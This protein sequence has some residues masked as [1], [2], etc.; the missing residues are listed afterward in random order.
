MSDRDICSKMDRVG[1]P[2]NIQY[3]CYN[4]L[5]QTPQYF[6]NQQC[7]SWPGNPSFQTNSFPYRVP[8]DFKVSGS[9]AAYIPAVT[10]NDVRSQLDTNCKELNRN[11]PGCSTTD[12]CEWAYQTMGFTD[13]AGNYHD[14]GVARSAYKAGFCMYG[15]RCCFMDASFCYRTAFDETYKNSCINKSLETDFGLSSTVWL[16]DTFWKLPDVPLT[17]LADGTFSGAS[18]TS[19]SYNIYQIYC[20]PSWCASNPAAD[21]V[22]FANCKNS[23]TMIGG[24]QRHAALAASGECHDWYTNSTADFRFGTH[25]WQL[26]DTMIENYCQNTPY[27]VDS[28][29]CNCVGGQPDR[30]QVPNSTYYT[31]CSAVGIGPGDC[32]GIVAPVRAAVQSQSSPPLLLSNPI[33]ANITCKQAISEFTSFATRNIHQQRVSCPEQSCFLTVLG[34]TFTAGNVNSSSVYIGSTDQ[35]CDN[36]SISATAP[37]YTVQ[38]FPTVWFWSNLKQEVLNPAQTALINLTNV[39][40]AGSGEMMQYSVTHGP[41]PSWL[42]YEGAPL[43]G[44]LEVGNVAGFSLRQRAQFAPQS[45]LIPFTFTALNGDSTFSQQ[46]VQLQVGVVATD[47]AVPV[48]PNPGSDTNPNDV[49]LLISN[50]LSPGGI[51][52][53]LLSVLFLVV[54]FV[55]YM[56]GVNI[57]NL[58]FRYI[59]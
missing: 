18:L 4:F 44:T 14:C 34:T 33:C 51:A 48:G 57:Q 45:D 31:S 42:Y 39:S 22:H 5:Q 10:T 28:Y 56:Q 30:L 53:V 52:L 13:I 25:N 37:K 27:S 6:T 21:A 58:A 38:E 20:D 35:F 9:G 41:L 24:A 1:A 3:D 29:S 46:I 49:P 59:K 7:D 15:I 54:S 16:K 36:R 26:I 8:F 32:A 40:P 43:F 50:K 23:V 19:Q 47:K 11:F 12:G 55:L 17:L 2:T